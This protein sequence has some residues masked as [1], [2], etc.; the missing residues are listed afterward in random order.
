MTTI[1]EIS[2]TVFTG[3][4]FGFDICNPKLFASKNRSSIVP[5]LQNLYFIQLLTILMS[6]RNVIIEKMSKSIL[7]G[8]KIVK[9]CAEFNGE[10]RFA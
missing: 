5:S 8:V 3:T 10:V 1:F 2:K 9:K 4:Y 7:T 6:K